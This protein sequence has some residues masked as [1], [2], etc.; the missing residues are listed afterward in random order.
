VTHTEQKSV[1]VAVY[2]HQPYSTTR[3]D[4]ERARLPVTHWAPH[5][6]RRSAR[7]LLASMGCPDAV[8][9]AVLGHMQPGIVGVYN[10]NQYDEERAEWL[11]RLSDR[12][13]ELAQ[14]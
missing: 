5:D 6:L 8:A 14:R 1:Q 7:T 4:L 2:Y 3:P 13:E 9:E 12:L 11:R 10:L